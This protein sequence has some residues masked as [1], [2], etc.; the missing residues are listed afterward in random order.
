MLSC[1]LDC[2]CDLKLAVS[3]GTQLCHAVMT[4]GEISRHS[5]YVKLTNRVFTVMTIEQIGR[6]CA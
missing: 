5:R 3:R 2:L 4:G 1:K 6:V